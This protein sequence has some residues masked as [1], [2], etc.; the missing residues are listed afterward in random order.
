MIAVEVD[1]LRLGGPRG[2]I[3]DGVGLRVPAGGRVALCGP[4]GCGKSTLARALL[5]ELPEGLRV[6]RGAIR[7]DG[8]DPL[9][10]RGAALRRL[11]RRC[12]YSDQDPGGALPPHRSIRAILRHRATGATDRAL[13]ELLG[14][15]R[16]DDVPGILDRTPAELSGGQRRR[17]G[18]AAAIAAE[19]E[20]LIVDEPTA[21]IDAAA[22]GDVIAAVAEAIRAC[23]ATAVVITHDAVV[24]AALADSVHRLD[25][26]AGPGPGQPVGTPRPPRG[27]P[28]AAPLLEARDLTIR[29]AGRTLVSG[30]DLV[31]RPGAITA[32]EG[33]SGSGK[34]TV[35]RT[36]LGLHHPESG[37]ILL[38]GREQAPT[39]T[40]RGP[41]AP[42][43]IAWVAQEADLALNP[44]LRVRTTLRRTG[45]GAGEIDALLAD[46]G[47][48]PMAR[49][50]RTRPDDLSGG[51]RQ[52]IAVALALLRRPRILLC[53]EPTSALDPDSRDLVLAALVRAAEAGVAVLISSHDPPTLA[54]AADRVRIPGS[55]PAPTPDRPEE[56]P[57]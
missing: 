57:R 22:C 8:A 28:A 35:L 52:R 29:Q 48:P 40:D 9:R 6:E 37:R 45:A 12:A 7:V 3:L 36:L 10:L 33:P 43:T 38:A 39:L 17:V 21:G 11:R 13:L 5:G 49:L 27:D 4:S 30:L 50:G 15:F 34:T 1:G 25:P 56:E 20:L 55:H 26:P 41:D 53:D 18:L 42:A 23:S 14:R 16:L 32:L 2:P 24:A 54:I 31:L 19:P 47:L 46:L 51:Q 44:A